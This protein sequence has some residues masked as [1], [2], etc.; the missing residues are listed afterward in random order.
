MSIL[1][2]IILI[3]IISWLGGFSLRLGGGLIH[4]LLVV[5]LIVLVFRLLS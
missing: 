1:D 4:L 2:I 5:A 3:L